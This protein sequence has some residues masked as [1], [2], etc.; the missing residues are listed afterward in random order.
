[1]RRSR[2]SGAPTTCCRHLLYFRTLVKALNSHIYHLYDRWYKSAGLQKMSKYPILE[3]DSRVKEDGLPEPAWD[4]V[5]L[6]DVAGLVNLGRD[7]STT[8][9]PRKAGL[10]V[11]G[12]VVAAAAEPR[13]V[14]LFYGDEAQ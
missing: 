8:V 13:Q 2:L 11:G 9:K 14:L 10:Q 7:S 6:G 3:W 12:G 4:C 5:P 1:M